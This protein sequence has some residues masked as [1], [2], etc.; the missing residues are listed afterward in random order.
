MFGEIDNRVRPLIFFIR[1]WAKCVG[2]TN[3]SPGRWI[4]NF[5]LTSLVIFFLQHLRAPILP[6]FNSLIQQARKNNSDDVRVAQGHINCTFLRDLNQLQFKCENQTP[7]HQLLL[8]FFEFYSQVNFQEKAISLNDGE[9]FT[10]PDH[11]AMYIMNPLE[12]ELNVCKNVSYEECER[13]RIEVRNAAWILESNTQKKRKPIDGDDDI[14]TPWGMLML[15]KTTKSTT[16][17]PT[18]FYKPRMV[19]VSEL[20]DGIELNDNRIQVNGEQNIDFRNNFVKAQVKNVR[21]K[22]RE[23]IKKMSDNILKSETRARKS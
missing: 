6:K 9:L 18:M 12:T 22:G 7:L 3:S 14:S 2:L 15:L 5:S 16:V 11:S 8:E 23:D 19:D 21:K 13:F 10:K 17:R 1:H 4:S 20:F